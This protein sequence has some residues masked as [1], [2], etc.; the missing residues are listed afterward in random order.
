MKDLN[1]LYDFSFEQLQQQISVWKQ[2]AYR[3]QQIWSWLYEH[4]ISH[5]EAMN[6]LP[7]PL[8]ERLADCFSL[9]RLTPVMELRSKDEST[10]KILFELSDKT[11]I[12]AVHMTYGGKNN[13]A[14]R[15]TL[16]ISSQAGCALGC[17]FC[18]T[19]QGGFQRNLTS[20]EIVEQVLFYARALKTQGARVT[21]IVFMG[22][23]EPFAN[24][25]NVMEAV[26]KLTDPKG[27]GLGARRLTISTVGLVPGIERFTAANTQVNLAI[28]LHAATD[29]LRSQS[30]P[31]NQRY[32][33][34]ALLKACRQYTKKTRRR[35][36]FEWAMIDHVND[37]IEQ[38][39]ILA[40]QIH[41]MLCHVNLIPLN[42]TQG[43]AGKASDPTR[44]AAFCAVLDRYGIPNS[45]RSRKGV[46]INAACGQL[47]RQNDLSIQPSLNTEST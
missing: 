40:E 12:E 9:S 43:F 19:G 35:I 23:G 24:Y 13:R 27:V 41:D 29:E 33:I 34:R 1:S 25:D 20:G 10:R 18:A 39:T 5:I 6:N 47:S 32:P 42:P 16:C 44:M 46:D 28:S 15:N 17:T 14:G 36:S 38:A 22:M 4:N 2:P 30:M 37:T 21:N 45:I 31:V 3:A 11:T 7:K 8:R 26:Q